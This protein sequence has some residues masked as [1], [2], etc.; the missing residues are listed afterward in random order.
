MRYIR[1]ITI[2]V[3]SAIVT[4]VLS[5]M[6]VNH[7]FLQG[8]G[9][10]VWGWGSLSW[11]QMFFLKFVYAF[12]ITLFLFLALDTLILILIF[13]SKL[14][15]WR[16]VLR[17]AVLA[18]ATG[19]TVFILSMLLVF[20][21]VVLVISI[22]LL[23]QYLNNPDNPYLSHEVEYLLGRL[24]YVGVEIIGIGVAAL[25]FFAARRRLTRDLAC[26]REIHTS[27]EES[28]D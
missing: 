19:I 16:K 20:H 11:G 27:T 18:I 24:A 10:E 7:Y 22:E 9:R 6:E 1:Y 25:I 23:T 4:F 3:G 13:G 14:T 8:G 28:L 5:Y 26:D 2:I 17:S 12:P 21:Y 15:V